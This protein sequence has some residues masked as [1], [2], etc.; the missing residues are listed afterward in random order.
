MVLAV[1]PDATKVL[2]KVLD[3]VDHEP[4]QILRLTPNQQGNLQMILGTEQDDDHV[5]EHNGDPVLAIS[6]PVS[7]KLT[8]TTL[9]VNEQEDLFFSQSEDGGEPH[10][11]R[12]G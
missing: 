7:E 8:G 10:N 12:V 5:I 1:T 3:D 6:L 2:K 9:D 4:D 11:G